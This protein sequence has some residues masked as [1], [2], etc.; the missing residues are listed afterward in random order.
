MITPYI[1]YPPLSGGQTRSYYLLKHLSENCDIT[2]INFQLPDQ[3]EKGVDHLKKFCSKVITVSRGKTWQIKKVLAAGLTPYPLLVVNYLSNELKQKI[4][5]ELENQKYDL[6]HVECF[7]LMPNIPK[8]KIPVLLVDQT[9]EFAVYQH[10]VQTLPRKFL[11]MKPFLWVDVLKIKYWEK[12]FWQ[13]ADCLVAVSEDDQ[14]LMERVSKRKTKVVRNGVNEEL[15]IDKKEYF[16]ERPT[17]FFGVANFNWMQNKEAAINLLKHIWPEIKKQVPTAKLVI[18]GR[19]SKKF[20]Q[21]TNL[22]P[23]N[24][25]DIK[26]GSVDNPA[27][28]YQ[29]ASVLVAPIRSGGGSRTKFFEAMACQLPIATTKEGIEGIEAV[30][31]KHAVIADNF[32]DLIEKTIELI[33]NREKQ[34]RIGRQGQKLVREKYSWRQSAEK[35]LKLYRETSKND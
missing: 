17:V 30:N 35:L 9:I 23:I 12:R 22:L 3:E 20:I 11:L 1:P 16:P 8:T 6:V 5:N 14:K 13:K 10:Y 21:S 28:A 32:D 31:N 15:I 4:K 26:V 2:L 24:N 27:K 25:K 19:H 18:A 34:K 33:N 29:K 7:Y